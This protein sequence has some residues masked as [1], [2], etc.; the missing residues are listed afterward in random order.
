MNKY[1]RFFFDYLMVPLCMPILSAAIAAYHV[2][3]ETDASS[4]ATLREAWPHLHQ[5]TRKAIA[6][7]M[8]A[9]KISR[10]DYQKLFGLALTD[11]GAI[12]MPVSTGTAA[13]ERAKLKDE[14]LS[15]T[16]SGDSVTI[17]KG[18]A[19]K[20]MPFLKASAL[21]EQRDDTSVGCAVMSDVRTNDDSAKLVIPRDSR[22]FGWKQHGR[23]EWTAWTTP[24]GSTVGDAALHGVAFASGVSQDDDALTVIALHDVVVPAIVASASM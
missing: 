16:A 8:T 6:A 9:G 21:L 10:W 5:P 2:T 12:A 22:L 7:A 4:Y 14:M 23:I 20:C 13:E 17:T 15:P 24:T 11:T 18:Q 19:F 3:G 1:R